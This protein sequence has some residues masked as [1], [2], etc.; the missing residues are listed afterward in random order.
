M[1]KEKRDWAALFDAASEAMASWRKTNKRAT[2]NEIE[3]TVDAQL[4]QLRAQ[5][6]QDL[7][8]ASGQRDWR[9]AAVGERPTCPSCG[10]PLQAN[11]EKQRTLV[12]DQEAQVK[13]SR[14][15]GTCPACGQS[16]FPPG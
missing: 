13:L 16:V 15:Q 2:F 5:I 6:M 1:E 3:A 14:Q 7:A 8:M 10:A 11:G 4:A 12:T 9:G